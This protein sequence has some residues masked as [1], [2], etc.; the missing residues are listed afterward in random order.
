MLAFVY[1]DNSQ[2]F[3]PFK[4][5]T[6]TTCAAFFVDDKGH[7]EVSALSNTSTSS[8]RLNCAL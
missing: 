4:T 1:E 5:L 8:L 2:Y 3:L 7:F 6:A